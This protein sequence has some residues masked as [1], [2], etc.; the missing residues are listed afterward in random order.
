MGRSSRAGR[1]R[2]PGPA[3]YDDNGRLTTRVEPRG[4]ASGADP[5]Q[6]TWSTGY[7]AAGNVVSET[8]PSG[9]KTVSNTYDG[10]GRLTERADA[11]GKKTVYG[12]DKLGRNHSTYSYDKVGNLTTSSTSPG[13]RTNTYDAADQL[14]KLVEGTTTVDFTYDADGSRTTT[15]KNNSLWRT[16]RW[17][18]VGPLAQIATETNS[19]GALIAEYQYNPAGIAVAQNR[20]TGT[21]YMRHDRQNSITAVYDAAGK[22]LAAA[23]PR[24]HTRGPLHGRPADA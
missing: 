2:R 15:N 22:G 18:L 7:D 21:F 10:D 17:D 4:N 16:T 1:P 14:T 24:G 5:S 8:D 23:A 12:Y 3:G 20:S 9:V 6:Y 13:I 11:L 19:S